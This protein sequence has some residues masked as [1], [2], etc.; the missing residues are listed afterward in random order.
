MS[1]IT[2]DLALAIVKKLKAQIVTGRKAHDIALVRHEGKLIATFG[3]RRGSKKDQGHDHIPS[4][5]FVRTG[6]A[7]LLGECP[8]SRDEWLEV[9]RSKSKI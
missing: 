4:A 3:I 9:L 2:K 6:Q 8:M 7:K 1:V 5:I